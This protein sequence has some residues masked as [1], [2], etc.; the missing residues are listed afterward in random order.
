MKQLL[1]VITFLASSGAFAQV[2]YYE[3][4][5]RQNAEYNSL[6]NSTQRAYSV[7]SN[8]SNN[9]AY[10]S[11]S[12]S[13]S[14]YSGS[15]SGGGFSTGSKAP[16]PLNWTSKEP[17]KTNAEIIEE[18]NAWLRQMREEKKKEREA[19]TENY[20]RESTKSAN[21]IMAYNSEVKRAKEVKALAAPFIEIGFTPTEAF[22]MAYGQVPLTDDTM[23]EGEEAQTINEAAAALERFNSRISVASY[24]ELASLA[25][26][27]KT[28]TLT[29][30]F[31]QH[32]LAA[33]FPDKKDE[34]EIAELLS[35]PFF[36]GGTHSVPTHVAA[37]RATES[38]RA[39]VID[40]L[41]YL[42]ARHTPEFEY[43]YSLMN[44]TA[45]T[46]METSMNKSLAGKGY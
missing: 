24:E 1:F 14:T 18:H 25:A 44:E 36:W 22:A 38:E 35:I 8:I 28:S 10:R 2:N 15:S 31:A 30:L 13:T 23:P 4:R 7:P 34:T 12:S 39:Q 6:S 32:A 29:Y 17:E 41:Y 40:R 26:M 33:R 3:S 37:T 19:W 42:A 43:V 45:F 11:S 9:P 20:K 27:F 16:E 5:A 21:Q 46:R